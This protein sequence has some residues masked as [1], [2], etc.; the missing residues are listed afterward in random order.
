MRF[1]GV[2]LGSFVALAIILILEY[3]LQTMIDHKETLA[4]EESNRENL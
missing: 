4:L 1:V 3:A 2:F